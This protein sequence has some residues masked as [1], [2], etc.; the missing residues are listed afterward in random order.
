MI[1]FRPLRTQTQTQTHKHTDTKTNTNTHMHALTYTHTHTH[2]QPHTQTHTH[3][4]ARARTHARTH[5]HTNTHAR[6]HAR[7]HTRSC[8]DCGDRRDAGCLRDGTGRGKYLKGAMDCGNSLRGG[9]VGRRCWSWCFVG[10]QDGSASPRSGFFPA[11]DF[12]H[13]PPVERDSLSPISA[14]RPRS[15]ENRRLHR[16]AGAWHEGGR[17]LPPAPIRNHLHSMPSIVVRLVPHKPPAPKL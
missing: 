10:D 11:R 5:A 8:C 9:E 3:T 1:R 13:C 16:H 4:H 17:S 12:S 15:R 6:T 7:T 14:T 2:T